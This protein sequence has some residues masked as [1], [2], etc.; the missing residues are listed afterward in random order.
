MKKILTFLLTALLAF[1]VGWA[2]EGSVSYAMNSSSPAA[3]SPGNSSGANTCVT[4]EGFTIYLSSSSAT[5]GGYIGWNSGNTTMT[6]SHESYYIREIYVYATANS[7]ASAYNISLKS[8]GGTF[9]ATSATQFNWIAGDGNDTHSVSFTHGSG[10]QFRINR[11]IIEYE[12]DGGS[13]G[14]TEVA[15]I[16]DAYALA[17]DTQFTF[18]GNAVVTYQNGN[19]LWIRDAS[20]SGLIYGSGVGTYSNGNIL[21]SGWTATNV[22]YNGIPEFTNPSG[23]S[24]SSQGSKVDPLSLT[25]LTTGDVNKY[26]SLSNVTI[27]SASGN[28]Y[29]TEI[30]GT[31]F[32][33]R[34]QYGL[35]ALTQGKTYNVVGIVTLYNNAIQFNLI[36]ATE[37]T[38]G[39]PT[40]IVSPTSLDINDSG[41]NNT[42]HVEG[43]NLANNDQGNVGVNSSSSDFGLSFSSSTNETATW[44]FIRN[45]GSVDGTVAVYYNGRALSANTT[46]TAATQGDSKSVAV[47]YVADLYIVTDNG[48]TNDWHFDGAYSEHMTNNNGVYTATFT[49]NTANTFILF[50]R[51]LGDGVTWGTRY[52]FG[53][54]SGGDWWLPIGG[55]GN[56]TIDVNTSNPIKIQE[57]GTYTIT[58][59]ANNN[60]FTIKKQV[61]GN[62]DFVLVTS[63][64]DVTAN[65]DYV[66]VY[67][68][69]NAMSTTLTSGYFTEV[70]DG[71]TVAN[72]VVTLSD[73]NSVNVLRLTSA[74]D[75]KFFIQDQNGN[76]IRVNGNN[77]A[78]SSS[79]STT[80]DYKWSITISNNLAI[81]QNVSTSRYIAYNTS[82]PRFNTYSSITSGSAQQYAALY[83]H[84]STEPS[85][86][87]NPSSLELVVPAGEAS[88]QGTVTVTE[89]NTTG[90][91]SVSIDGDANLFAANLENG[92]L[93]VTY[94]GNA[95]QDHPD[96]AT[97]TLTNGTAS[98]TVTVTGYKEPITVTFNPASGQTFTSSTMSGTIE[99]NVSGATIEYSLDG[100]QTWITATDGAFT[101]NEV[102]V[103]QTVTVQARATY[104]GVTSEIATATYTRVDASA[105]LYT[106]VTSADQI[107]AGLQ[108]ILV[109]EGTPE[110][111]NDITT[112]TGGTGATVTWQTQGL[113]VNIDNTDVIQ[114]TLEGDEERAKFHSGDLYLGRSG[115]NG[116]GNNSET[117]WMIL[118]NE[119]TSNDPGGFYLAIG[120][121]SNDFRLRYNTGMTNADKFRCYSNNT[122]DP[123]YLYVQGAGGVATPTITPGS[124]NYA[125]NQ[126]V[127]IN[128]ATQDAT[129]YYTVD[130]GEAQTYTEPFTVTLDEDHTSVT[131]VAW[132]EK[133]DETSNQVT[134]TYN[135]KSDKVYSIAEFLALENG[136]E[137]YFINPVTVL[138]DYSQNSSGGQEYIWVKDR[139]GY[140]QFFIVPAFDNTDFIPKYENGDVIPA[141]FK[142]KK[143]YYDNGQYY[144]GMCNND[145]R[146]TFVDATEKALADPEQVLLSELLE[147]P[148]DYNNRYLYINKLQVS[149]ASGLNFSISADE[150]GDDVSEV[151]GGSAIVGYNKYNS[152]AWKN[153]QGDV[154]GVTLPTDDKYYNVTFIFQKWQN[155]YEMM[156]IEFTEWQDN[157][158]RLEDLVATGVEDNQYTISNTLIAA[159]VTWDDSKGK[160]AIFAKDDEMY[161][162]KR[163][164]AEGQEEYLIEFES[165]DGTFVNTVEQSD[166]D[167]SNWIE[168]L[169]PSDITDKTTNPNA[170]ESALEDLKSTYQNKILAGGSI[171]GTYVDAL[172]PTI[173][174]SRVPTVEVNSTY[175]PNIYCTGNFL[176]ENIDADGAMSYRDDELGG[177]YFFFMDSKPQEFCKVVWAYFIGND[178]Y[179]VAPAQEGYD[180]NG[181]KF[182]GSF[183]AD[184]SLCEDYRVSA[185]TPVANCFNPSNSYGEEQ[186]LYGF[187]AIVRK[188]P[189]AWNGGSNGA[190]S[191]IQPYE[192]G[193]ES[194]PLYIVYP[195]S[196]GSDS[197]D[198][199]TA[200]EEVAASKTVKSVR[201]Y[202]LMGME[203]EQPFQ[204]INIV[205]TRYSDGSIST[206]KVMR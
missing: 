51:K 160:F 125:E 10:K 93:T 163:Y 200:V 8:G 148:A 41:T 55:N 201:Y 102:A 152:P 94:T 130:G 143:N 112:N 132:A 113:V 146:E 106:K 140:T 27:S 70:S 33:L 128:C 197:S 195:L 114:F 60:T 175:T 83:K 61:I 85:I 116:L 68:E 67:N 162:N 192:D 205:V 120:P 52:L 188:N 151:A 118:E 64:D 98:A 45:N 15:T 79:A 22:V 42:F 88:K 134:V 150:N 91:T 136:D 44:G 36:S 170:Y 204:G 50:A 159:R 59:N 54:S 168:I 155:G 32:H 101:T 7:T 187:E 121:A 89:S 2:A 95:T 194:T 185:Q 179:F 57:A 47:N 173:E 156:P 104:N 56:G 39:D 172:N 108:Y 6:I 40:I 38:S 86:T 157:S 122:G 12:T 19:N 158:V 180:I 186:M 90:T 127:T 87:V 174:V 34:N 199:V 20:G 3:W 48:V 144:Q 11:I 190:P 13:T 97:I 66:L 76:Y 182:R 29:Y 71:F 153:K 77:L 145:D 75:G 193:K 23:V 4:A 137:A 164:P 119:A 177:E 72:N 176:A 43:Y 1:S 46:V 82:S 31:T 166:Y 65:D 53:P 73:E 78:T 202:N 165:Q 111:I 80:D 126:V 16:A 149:D 183:L 69:T 81:I 167:Q 203:S 58:I 92:T 37:V 135:Y 198:N 18:T 74:G 100:G 26:A 63:T 107:Q 206:V 196:Q 171:S 131:I 109:Y 21:N 154:V 161:A 142:V 96:G 24:L 105:T 124:G 99:C 84:G 9:Q 110:A 147:N 115:T 133:D 5:N 30:G 139:T 141:G 181:H 35:D 25:T 129:I 49:A 117:V 14:P 178:N 103:G 123:V 138:F 17:Q 189:A 169:I 184:M 191:R 62:N 28:D